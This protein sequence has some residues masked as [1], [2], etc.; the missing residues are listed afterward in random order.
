MKVGTPLI[1]ELGVRGTDHVL[2]DILRQETLVVLEIYPNNGRDPIDEETK[3]ILRELICRPF[4][5]LP[6]LT[7]RTLHSRTL[8][9][10]DG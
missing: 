7:E 9:Y 1:K 8:T 2:K 5:R 6:L 3:G 4:T 10:I